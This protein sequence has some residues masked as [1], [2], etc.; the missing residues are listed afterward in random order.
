MF[1]NDI[2]DIQLDSSHSRSNLAMESFETANSS[3]NEWLE[4][5]S[6]KE[7]DLNETDDTTVSSRA[8][9]WM[10]QMEKKANSPSSYSQSR[11]VFSARAD[12]PR[13][14]DPPQNLDPPSIV[15]DRATKRIIAT[16]YSSGSISNQT[17]TVSNQQS[18]PLEAPRK[19]RVEELISK[20]ENP[21]KRKQSSL[22][23][24]QE[25]HPVIFHSNAMGIR[26]KR[27]EDGLVRVVSVT[28]SS[29]GSSIVR[30]GKIEP[31]DIVREA[32]GAD[33]RSPI[34]NSQ[35]GEI[36]LQIRNASRPMKFVIVSA[37]KSSQSE[38]A[39][40]A[41]SQPQHTSSRSYSQ[42]QRSAQQ[43]PPKILFGD[44]DSTAGS[45]D[46]DSSAKQSLLSRI[47][48]CAAPPAP[49]EKAEGNEVPLAHLAFLRTNPTI[50]RVR[51]EASRRYP[52]LCGRP[53]TIFEE[54]EDAE[55]QGRTLNN[56][57]ER[58]ADTSSF[59]ASAA[60]ISGSQP[61]SRS[62]VSSGSSASGDNVA[63][64]EGLAAK[65]AVSN[66]SYRS[67]NNN[68]QKFRQISTGRSSPTGSNEVEWPDSDGQM[69]SREPDTLSAYNARSQ[70][71]FQNIKRDTARQ[72]ELLAESKVVAMMEQELHYVDS[73][74][75]C[76]I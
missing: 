13:A 61:T 19:S 43:K 75:E 16:R 47:S 4:T 74:E 26:L 57:L 63:Y 28:E 36:V 67:R 21:D 6:P 39:R 64:L 60:P 27:G 69:Y 10:S 58:S 51:N 40:L 52:A 18:T 11:A 35:W 65:A 15:S 34:S 56:S 23:V 72:A 76:E 37:R 33:L 22:S 7:K 54:P 41:T 38:T 66:K 24:E 59:D 62:Y 1:E 46:D 55:A 9:A 44:D 32:A 8:L 5:S 71:S 2:S 42:S 29:P 68:S 49:K 31:D 30:D 12:P 17:P 70:S 50:A 48:K 73:A 45:V 20:L 3:D 25:E 14:S 53:D